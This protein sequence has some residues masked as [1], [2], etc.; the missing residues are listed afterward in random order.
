VSDT[1]RETVTAV[2]EMK[3]PDGVTASAVAERLN[4]DKSA[5]SRRL[6]VARSKG[7]IRNVEDKKGKPGRWVVGD[8]M[9]ESSGLLP[10]RDTVAE[11][12]HAV[13]NPD[14]T[15]EAPSDHAHT[16]S[17]QGFYPP[18]QDPGADGC[19]VARYLEGYRA[20]VAWGSHEDR[21]QLEF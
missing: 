19:T 9:P 21:E 17:D 16:P 10:D 13:A 12:L 11:A 1:I 8:P 7:Y 6:L 14:A 4:L 20:D 3:E 5:A 15:A 18:D 2:A